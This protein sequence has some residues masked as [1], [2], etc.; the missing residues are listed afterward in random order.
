MRFNKPV[1][2]EYYNH[3]Y[4]L[5]HYFPTQWEGPIHIFDDKL[6]EIGVYGMEGSVEPHFHIITDG[7]SDICIKIM[8]NEY[9]RH[10]SI[11]LKDNECKRLND[12]LRSRTDCLYKKSENSIWCDIFEAW[13]NAGGNVGYGYYESEKMIN[14]IPDYS[15]INYTGDFIISDL[16]FVGH[17]DT[18]L[19]MCKIEFKRYSSIAINI[20]CNE[21]I[22][23]WVDLLNKIITINCRYVERK[24]RNELYT[25]INGWLNNELSLNNMYLYNYQYIIMQ[26]LH[27]G[28]VPSIKYQKAYYNAR[29]FK[30]KYIFQ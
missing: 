18:E 2:S 1:K 6:S 9:Y 10:P 5:E 30:V 24:Y 4:D 19:G 12:F 22:I 20:I 28:L 15:T 3:C 29:E 16:G 25:I 8:K 27:A 14:S 26:W 23:G 17:M 7:Y 21:N 11:V 13:N